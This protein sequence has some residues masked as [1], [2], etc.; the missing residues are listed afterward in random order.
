LYF[1]KN[2]VEEKGALKSVFKTPF[3]G[4]GRGKSADAF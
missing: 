1:V 4:F 2:V 3:W